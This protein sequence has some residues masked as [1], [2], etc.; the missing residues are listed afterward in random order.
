MKLK[1]LL[2]ICGL[3]TTT[4]TFASNFSSDKFMTNNGGS[5]E[6]TFIKHV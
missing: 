3:L 5:L 2:C 4:I 6:I 1:S